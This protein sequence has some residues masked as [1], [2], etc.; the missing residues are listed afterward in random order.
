MSKKGKKTAVKEKEEEGQ[1]KE[2]R[3]ESAS[4]EREKTRKKTASRREVDVDSWIERNIDEVVSRAG[5]DYLS[6]DRELWFE[7]LRDVLADLYGSTT[8]YKSA[9]DITKRLVRS[10]ERVLPVIAARLAHVLDNPSADQLEFIVVNIGDAVLD[11]APRI[12]TW[13]GRSGRKDLLGTLKY[14]WSSTWSR[15]R[16][17]VLPIACPR[18]GFNSLMPD[19]TCIVCGHSTTEKELK[20]SI[21]FSSRLRELLN[22]VDCSELKKL[23]NYDYVLVNDIEI[24]PPSFNR[25]PIDVEV[26]LSKTDKEMVREAYRSRCSSSEATQ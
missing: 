21:G 20:E 13:I 5:L 2:S 8:S 24:K 26:Y 12:Y 9:D 1:K 3:E 22:S 25:L 23:A 17:P 15:T 7:V 4:E 6:L 14:K 11:L 19:L 16:T 18:C 10:S